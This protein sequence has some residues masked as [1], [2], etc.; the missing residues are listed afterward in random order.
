MALRKREEKMREKMEEKIIQDG[1]DTEK[2]EKPGSQVSN[3]GVLLIMLFSMISAV[4]VGSVMKALLPAEVNSFISDKFISTIATMYINALKMMVGPLVFFSIASSI[5]SF[6]DFKLLGKMAAFIIVGY[7]LTSMFATAVGYLVYSLYPIGTPE[8]QSA[9]SSAADSMIETSQTVDVSLKATIMNIVPSDIITPFKE[10]N[11]LQIIFISV[12]VG[13]AAAAL[14]RRDS[15]YESFLKAINELFG[16]VISIIVLVLP[17]VVF[18]SILKLVLNMDLKGL[19]TVLSCI[20]VCYLGNLLMICVYAA[21]LWIFGG[22]NPLRFLVKFLPVSFIAYSFSSS[23]ATMPYTMGCCDKKLGIDR[24]LY[25]FSIPLGAT[26]NMDGTCVSFMVVS[27]FLARVFGI[28]MTGSALFTLVLAVMVLSVGAPGVPGSYL[29]CMAL[30]LP[31]IGVPVEALSLIIGVHTFIGMGNAFVNT[32][33]DAV[34]S[35]IVAKRLGL[36][37]E[38]RYKA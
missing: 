17:L 2:Q 12:L 34:I 37:D 25:S 30:I 9:V 16:K 5:V 8:L 35:T 11:M 20:P 28:Q 27:M 31:E 24:K 6:K 23:N 7:L 33:G 38:K 15:R 10:S 14:G 36:L 18:C 21:L 1:I 4:V 26:I 32:T 3:T 29:V 22:L 13:L 19:G